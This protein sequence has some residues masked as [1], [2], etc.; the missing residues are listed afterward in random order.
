MKEQVKKFI[1][2]IHETTEYVNGM[3]NEALFNKIKQTFVRQKTL[4]MGKEKQK[5]STLGVK[6]IWRELTS[7]CPQTGISLIQNTQFR[8][9]I[10]T[11]F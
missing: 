7:F 3:N 10:N 11:K 5:G 6:L 4:P 2:S 9:L 1:D 8:I